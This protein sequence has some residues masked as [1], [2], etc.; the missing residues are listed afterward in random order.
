MCIFCSTFGTPLPKINFGWVSTPKV[1]LR[2]AGRTQKWVFFAKPRG[3]RIQCAY[4]SFCASI[5]A[6]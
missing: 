5:N 3:F 6:Q 4:R 2:P 1:R